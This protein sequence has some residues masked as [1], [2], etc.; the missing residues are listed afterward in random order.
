MMMMNTFVATNNRSINSTNRLLH[1]YLEKLHDS[2]NAN[3]ARNVH[4]NNFI[5][6]VRVSVQICSIGINW[7]RRQ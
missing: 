5:P 2:M 1:E 3:S 6:N 4:I 7:K